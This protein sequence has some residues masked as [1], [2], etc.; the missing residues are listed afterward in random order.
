[1][2]VLS[3]PVRPLPSASW[4]ILFG[5]TAVIGCSRSDSARPVA[6]ARGSADSLIPAGPYG[7]SVRRGRALLVATPDNLPAHVR[8][9]PRRT[10]CH[11]DESRR[12]NGTWGG[13][14]ARYPQYRPRRGVVEDTRKPLQDC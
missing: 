12:G 9:K 1:M 7:N 2:P 14:V 11:L 13:G 4:P 8:N 5:I 3:R 10:S 6:T